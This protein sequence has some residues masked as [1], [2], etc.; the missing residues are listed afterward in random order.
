MRIRLTEMYDQNCQGK[1][2][3]SREQAR[4]TVSNSD[5]QQIMELDSL[6]LGFFV[7]HFAWPSGEFYVLACGRQVEDE[8]LVDLAFKVLPQLIV[9]LDELQPIMLLQQLVHRFGLTMKIGQQLNRFIMREEIVID[10]TSTDPIQVVEVLNPANHTVIQTLFVMIDDQNGKRIIKCA[11]AYAIDADEYVAWLFGRQADQ[12]IVVDIAPQLHGHATPRD[13]FVST[14]TVTFRTNYNEVAPGRAGFLFRVLT[15]EYR[16]ELGF[17]ETHYYIVR[18]Q[19]RLEIPIQP[20]YK[21]TGKVFCVAG[22]TPDQLTLSML[23]GAYEEVIQGLSDDDRVQETEKRKRVL[24]TPPIL[25]PNSLLAWAR[26]NT[27]APVTTFNSPAEF[28]QIVTDAIQSIED[29]VATLG[30]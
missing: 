4:Q 27:I 20:V 9:G 30:L 17:N 11:I 7:K 29:K 2:Q 13:L 22:W 18:N 24:I 15:K 21:P 26:Q 16:L 25:P 3:I 8:W 1:F 12:D 23:D 28:Y 10:R 6:R 14:G 19:D 5:S